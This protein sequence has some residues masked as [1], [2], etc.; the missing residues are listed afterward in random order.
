MTT[1]SIADVLDVCYNTVD[2]HLR[3]IAL[4]PKLDVWV[5]H[6]LND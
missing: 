5:P 2:R 1:Q 4:V 6:D 3:Q